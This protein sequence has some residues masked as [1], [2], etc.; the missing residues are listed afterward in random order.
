M[1]DGDLIEHV[2]GSG[3]CRS[4]WHYPGLCNTGRNKCRVLVTKER[5]EEQWPTDDEFR[6][7]AAKLADAVQ[8]RHLPVT[9]EDVPK[10]CCPL[11]CTEEAIGWRPTPMSFKDCDGYN[12]KKTRNRRAFIKGFDG[13]GGGNPS[14]SY[15]R[16][17][18]EYRKRFIKENQNG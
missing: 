6:R 13:I 11:G 16:L 14:N 5:L 1:K 2:T 15:Y 8:N 12:G 18:Q 7:F 17:G 3:L 4:K 9:T 10:T